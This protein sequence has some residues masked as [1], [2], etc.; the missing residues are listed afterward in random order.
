MI[1]LAF[2]FQESA[3]E[4]FREQA[5]HD[6]TTVHPVGLLAIVVLWL[7]VVLLPRRYA[8]IPFL[9]SACLIPASQRV[10]IATLDFNVLR[11][12]VLAGWTRI[13]MRGE[14]TAFR[15]GR[16]DT[17]VLGWSISSAVAYVLLY[18]TFGAVIYRS[19]NLYDAL[20]LYLCFRCILR[21]PRDIELMARWAAGLSITMAA[22]FALEKTT[23]RNAFAFLGGVP[24]FTIE[25]EGRLRVQ[26]PFPHA[27]LAGCFFAAWLPL[28]GNLVWKP[29]RRTLAILGTTAILVCV[30]LC[31]SSTPVGG[32]LAGALGMVLWM[33]RRHMR[34]VRWGVVGVLIGLHFVME[35]PVWHLLSRVSF[36]QGST[37]YHRFML[38]DSTIRHVD[39]WAAIGMKDTSHWG[40]AMYDLANQYVSEAVRGGMLALVLFVA[41]LGYA[42]ALVGRMVKQSDLTRSTRLMIWGLGVSLFAQLVIFMGISIT[43]SQQALMVLFFV[44]A[45]IGS[46]AAATLQ[47]PKQRLVRALRSKRAQPTGAT[48]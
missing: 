23:G 44:L 46:L 36:S 34:V 4:G 33:Q 1:S 6:V 22:F 25:R 20:G 24:E 12:L 15:W 40:H 18:G 28:V 41:T 7:S 35:K 5:F 37:S 30:I 11:L 38:I 3:P 13:A 16:L 31:S 17:L 48:S 32:V 14:Y 19:G 45:S 29:E 47:Q 8:A 21:S 26:G 10:V 39:E 2:A 9:I 42:F 27:I 43:Y